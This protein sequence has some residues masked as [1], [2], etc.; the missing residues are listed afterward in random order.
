[1][2]F[3]HTKFEDSAVMRSLERLAKEKNLLPSQTVKTASAT[4]KLD[5][6]PSDNLTS[7][8]MILCA[9]LRDSGMYKQAQELEEKF[10]T[11]KQAQTLYETSKETGEDLVDEAHPKGSPKLEGV[12]AGDLAIIETIVDQ[13]MKLLDVVNKN[14]TGKLASNKEVINAV[15]MVLGGDDFLS[16]KGASKVSLGQLT[17][18]SGNKE[19]SSDSSIGTEVGI[20]ASTLALSKAI[21]VIKNWRAGGDV[22]EYNNAL[23][24]VEKATARFNK[25]DAKLLEKGMKENPAIARYIKKVNPKV[26]NSLSK[27]IAE[28]AA[29]AGKKAV[30]KGT[31]Q[32]GKKAVEKGTQKAVEK[33]TQQAAKQLAQKGT[34]QVATQVATKP[35]LWGRA[36][37]F[38]KSPVNFGGAA[39]GGGAAAE[40]GAAAA[41][42]AAVEGGAAA[43]EGGAAAV[44]IGAGSTVAALAASAIIAGVA[45]YLVTTAIY[46][47]KFYADNLQDAS[48]KL[49]EELKDVQKIPGWSSH[50]GEE[51]EFKQK[52]AAAM[53]AAEVA[54]GFTNNPSEKAL[55]ALRIYGD[56][57][58][59]ASTAAYKLSTSARGIYSGD[60]DMKPGESRDAGTGVGDWI[61]EN[62]R[63][64]NIS[65]WVGADAPQLADVMIAGAEFVNVAQKAISEVRVAMNGVI[66]VINKEVAKENS[67]TGGNTSANLLK[68]YTDT[69]NNI[70]KFINVIK[71]KEAAKT[72]DNA[73]AK[74]LIS[75][76]EKAQKLINADKAKFEGVDASA[77][78]AVVDTYANRFK[79][80]SAKL[81]A[82]NDKYTQVPGVV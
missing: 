12:D 52:F 78:Y 29:K 48:N 38:L 35:G 60:A 76:L 53:K 6:S 54:Q 41:G 64:S 68:S 19:S 18:P 40:G 69:L 32:A 36:L 3:K 50:V 59:D 43:V 1:M 26:A 80:Y 61:S 4:P 73:K 39:A 81:K 67:Q 70:T 9:G 33:G 25:A 30:E 24:E 17:P 28:K 46:N 47:N 57:L 34:E 74:A 62:L 66:D 15:K 65:R 49:L 23:K 75:W 5:L 45:T 27:Q 2:T 58:Q 63:T 16:A 20:A 10:F 56:A 79:N 77:R 55:D 82:F 7:N 14:P 71:A 42:T 22:R 51:A 72:L 11:Y 44:G 21:S 8:I 13:Q 37:R 31:Q